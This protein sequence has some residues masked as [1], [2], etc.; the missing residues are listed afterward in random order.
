MTPSSPDG[1]DIHALSNIHNQLDVGI[2]VVVCAAGNLDVVVGH[3]NVFCVGLQI[4]GG[5]HDSEVNGSLV[6][7][8]LVS[9]F[10]D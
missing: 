3:S 10:S 5:G 7:E 4:F 6:T 1:M 2:V 9:P 8:R